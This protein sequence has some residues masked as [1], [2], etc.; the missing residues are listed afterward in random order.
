MNRKD[1]VKIE[2]YQK[3]LELVRSGACANPFET[4]AEKIERIALA[5]QDVKFMVEY[6][7]PHYATAECAGFHIEW[8]NLVEKNHVFKGFS[9]WGRGLAKSVWNNIIIPFWLHIND[10]PC[11]FVI[12]GNSYD[13]AEQL[14][15]DIKAEF[16]TNERI[17]NDFGEQKM[18][19]SWEDG[20]FITKSGFIGQA[21]GMGQSVR[22]LRIKSL[23]PTHINCDD[24]EDKQLVK[25]PKR[26]NEMVRWV[27]RDLIPTMDGAYRRFTYSNNRFAPKM[28][29]TILQE[30]HPKWKVHRVN[31]YN[32]ITYEATWYQKYDSQYYKNIEEELGVLAC[33]AEYNN[34]PHIEGEI[35][36]PN[37][38]QYAKLP[39]IDSFDMIVGH[40]DVAYAGSATSD[41]NA[42]RIWGSKDKKFY[43]IDCF[44]K[45]TTMRPAVEFMC[46]WQRNN[47]NARIHWRF[48]SQF[49]NGEV[50]RTIQD[51]QLSYSIELNLTKVNTAKANK[52]DRILSLHPYYQNGR[53]FYNEKLKAHNDTSEGIAQLLGIEPG[54]K[55]HDDAPDADQQAI[56]W[57]SY[58]CRVNQYKAPVV[59]KIISK[60]RF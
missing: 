7:F 41:Y 40:W 53:I 34:E 42:V 32:P 59:T 56:E 60:N 37:L 50:E 24:M 6:Y 16:E 39:R 57:L 43:L 8:A 27:E 47:P 9:E 2:R 18:L 46:D 26:Q 13:K 38:I 20:F 21:L 35:F 33:K 14:L 10:I 29:Q 28:I 54:Y 17:I 22:G 5:K 1:K 44:V 49:W 15:E 11:Y 45:Q 55:G 36:T 19:G 31:A 30:K 51:V 25:N 4:E 48:E 58:H 12:I 23:R 52:Y 3:K